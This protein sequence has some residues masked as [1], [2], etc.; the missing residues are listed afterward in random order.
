MTRKDTRNAKKL[1]CRL[2]EL[3]CEVWAFQFD[4]TVNITRVTQLCI[5]IS[6][7]S[8]QNYILYSFLVRGLKWWS[9]IQASFMY[10]RN[11]LT[12]LVFELENIKIE[13]PKLKCTKYKNHRRKNIERQG[14][15]LRT[16]LSKEGH[17]I[18]GA[19]YWT[20]FVWDAFGAHTSITT[21]IAYSLRWLQLYKYDKCFYSEIWIHFLS[22]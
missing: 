17:N 1:I 20:V 15:V 4:T 11:T 16:I 6:Y 21:R 8:I 19:H 14:H 2:L 7:M 18:I 10:E 22:K 3:G 13:P 9:V 12:L 5:S